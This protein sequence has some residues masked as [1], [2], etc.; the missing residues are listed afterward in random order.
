[1]KD[2]NRKEMLKDEYYFLTDT[3]VLAGEIMLK[4]G[5]EV[6]RVEDT[7]QR[8]LKTSKLQQVETVVMGTCIIASLSNPDMNAIT[9]SRRIHAEGTDLGKI[10]D[11][12][13]ISRKY[14]S[15]KMSLYETFHELKKVDSSCRYRRWMHLAASMLVAMSFCI[16]YGGSVTDVFP[17]I[18][19]GASVYL[20]GEIGSRLKLASFITVLMS[21][22][23]L[24]LIAFAMAYILPV[25]VH[26][27]KV[28]VGT[29]MLLVPGLAL[30][31]ASRDVLMGNYIS[32][33]ARLL[34]ALVTALS[35]AL[36][37]GFAMVIANLA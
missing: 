26:T 29:L 5:A 28:I 9:V 14:C 20:T 2:Q 30:T 16:L 15:G 33:S 34:E 36:G 27:D 6:Y 25:P 12:N 18:L 31:N 32:G 35:V 1:M 21:S 7:I 17:A 19:C 8:I 10:H 22:F 3:A 37:A 11:V 4:H 23:V 13:D 24:S